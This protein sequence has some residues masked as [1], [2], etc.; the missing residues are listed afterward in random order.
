MI[1]IYN[2]NFEWGFIF[3]YLF[4]YTLKIK[5][6]FN[7]FYLDIWTEEDGLEI[8]C[9]L[10]DRCSYAIYYRTLSLLWLWINCLLFKIWIKYVLVL[11]KISLQIRWQNTRE[12]KS[13][14]IFEGIVLFGK[15]FKLVTK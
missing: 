2:N 7:I 12:L 3:K 4:C 15:K 5:L 8:K 13:R 14:Q 11:V 10:R 6:L 1:F 9:V